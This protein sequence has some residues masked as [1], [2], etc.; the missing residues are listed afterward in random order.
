MS[1]SIWTNFERRYREL[2]TSSD[3]T[4]DHERRVIGMQLFARIFDDKPCGCERQPGDDD[5]VPQLCAACLVGRG[6]E[7]V[8]LAELLGDAWGDSA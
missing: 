6:G 3:P 4:D 1:A 7:R 5:F 8:E 2:L